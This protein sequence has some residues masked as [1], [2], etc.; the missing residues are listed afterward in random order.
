MGP[1]SSPRNQEFRTVGESIS[2]A[3]NKLPNYFS[4]VPQQPGFQEGVLQYFKKKYPDAIHSA[5]ARSSAISHPTRRRGLATSTHSPRPDTRSS[6]TDLR[7]DPD[8]LHGR[9]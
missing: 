3:M 5:S 7:R 8:R 2:L 1:V 6:T 4:A 9:M